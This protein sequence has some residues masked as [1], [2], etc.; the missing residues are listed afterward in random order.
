M[1]IGITGTNGS[2]KDVAAKYFMKSG[3]SFYSLS[4]IIRRECENRGL[5]KDRDSLILM[6]NS[7]RKNNGPSILAKLTMDLIKE[8][9]EDLVIVG[10]IRHEK[11]AKELAKHPE[12]KLIAIDAPIEKR[13]ERVKKRLSEMDDVTFEKFRRQEKSEMKGHESHMETL[14]SVINMADEFIVNDSTIDDF[15]SKLA[16][17][18]SQRK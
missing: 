9:K 10:S 6:G 2:G 7:L 1:I 14:H 5:S 11:E 16:N 8:R 3:F 15:H 18:L 12:F 17:V 4:D 13:F